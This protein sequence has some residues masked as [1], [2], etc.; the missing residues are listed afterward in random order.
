MA[1]HYLIGGM[2]M[3][4]NKDTRQLGIYIG[5]LKRKTEIEEDLKA[6]KK[7]LEDLQPSV[8]NWFAQTGADK[9][10]LD[11]YTLSPRRE[12]WASYNEGFNTDTAAEYLNANGFPQY[13]KLKANLKTL[14]SHLRE[15]DRDGDPVEDAI[16]TVVT[17]RETYKVGFSV[18]VT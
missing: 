18:K 16:A 13:A 4:E 7:H 15:C 8:L 14:T 6:V 3:P 10:S 1:F 17:G 11:G 9:I 12:L 5:Y 2:F